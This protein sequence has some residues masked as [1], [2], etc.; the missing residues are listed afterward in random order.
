MMITET[1]AICSLVQEAFGL[2]KQTTNHHIYLHINLENGYQVSNEV[3]NNCWEKLGKAIWR[4]NLT[5]AF[6]M[7]RLE[8]GRGESGS[9]VSLT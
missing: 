2:L 9:L 7:S 3:L 4:S 6:G 8:R 1:M 5:M